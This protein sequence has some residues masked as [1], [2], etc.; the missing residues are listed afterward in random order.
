MHW[1]VPALVALVIAPAGARANLD[2]AI[3][4]LQSRSFCVNADI[5]TAWEQTA[6]ALKRLEIPVTLADPQFHVTTTAFVEAGFGRLF[7]IA[8]NPRSFRG[9]RFTFKI[10]L[11]EVTPSFTK[12]SIILQIRQKKM[13]GSSERLLKSRGSFEKYLAYEINRLAIAKKYPDLL[14]IR[15]GMD[16]IP[17]LKNERYQIQNVEA[18]SPAAEAGFKSGDWLEAIDGKKIS[19]RDGLFETLL[20]GG[21]VKR[22]EFAVLRDSVRLKIP[23]QIIRVSQE[24][25]DL[26]VRFLGDKPKRPSAVAYVVPHSR[27]EKAGVRIGDEIL[28]I[29]GRKIGS[30]TDYYL[31]LASGVEGHAVSFLMRR[32]ERRVQAE[33]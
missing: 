4:K 8:K 1:M 31:A 3:A 13:V 17:S 6:L 20:A 32:G 21:K 16:L 24:A 18:H 7:K 15:L 29:G 22:M 19:V 11:E 10:G 9:G 30:W 23:V 33:V 28:E 12:L 5:G 2:K 25:D 26:G 27:A 14:E